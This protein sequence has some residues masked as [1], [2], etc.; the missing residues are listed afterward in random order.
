MGILVR[1]IWDFLK[2]DFGLTFRFSMI[3]ALGYL[4]A[5]PLI[6][7]ITNLNLI[8][9][10]RC[11]EESVSLTGIILIVP[12]SRWEQGAGIREV[13]FSKSWTYLRTVSLRLMEAFLFSAMLAGG[14]AAIMRR[15]N[16][17][18]PY[19]SYLWK[20]ELAVLLLGLM[21]LSVSMFTENF[22]AGYLF[23]FGYYALCKLEILKTGDVLYLFPLSST[24]GGNTT[25][26]QV[27]LVDF[28]LGT[29]V[30]W[31]AARNRET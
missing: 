20:C 27:V 23:A 9:S 8:Q 17:T 18:F 30:L 13:V 15:Q 4:C 31:M 29:G 12:L 28:V 11:L 16:C 5:I 26:A 10:A 21:G 22:V 14:F 6:R 19:W 25:L 24:R 1:N 3:L 2:K 7:G